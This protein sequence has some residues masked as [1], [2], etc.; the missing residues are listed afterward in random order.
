LGLIRTES[1]KE[2]LYARSAVVTTAV[3]YGLQ[4]IDLVCLNYNNESALE[5][6]CQEG[7]ELGFTGKQ[8]IHPRQIPTIHRA[9]AP[10]QSEIEYASRIVAGY[11][12]HSKQGVG[13]FGLDG[14]VVDMPVVKWAQRVLEKA[15]LARLK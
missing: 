11:E 15:Q 10:Q 4:S 7:R 3:A 2:L 5:T 14:K 13:A 9:F 1:R 8:A 6:E 12:E